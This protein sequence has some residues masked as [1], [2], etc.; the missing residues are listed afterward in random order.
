MQ[1]LAS[2]E[3]VDNLKYNGKKITKRKDGRWWARYYQ[4][5]I[6][7]SVYG[8][9]QNECIANLKKALIQKKKNKSKTILTLEDWI[10]KWIE[11]YKIGK[12][13]ESTL[14]AM[15]SRLKGYVLSNPIASKKLSSI[16]TIELQELLNAIEKD[17]QR[18][19]IFTHLRDIFAKAQQTALIKDNPMQ[20]VFIKKH[21]PKETRAYDNLQEKIFINHCK[22][23]GLYGDFYLLMLYTGLRNGELRALARDDIDFTANT[24]SVSKTYDDLGNITTPKTVESIRTVPLFEP[25]KQILLKYKAVSGIIFNK[26]KCMF[27]KNFKKLMIEIGWQNEGF[28]INSGRHTFI[29]R[30]HEQGLEAKQIEKWVGHSDNSNISKKHYIHI[31]EDFEAKNIDKVNE[32]FDTCF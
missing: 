31:N 14:Y 8:K 4:N 30:L 27:Q 25:A 24:I 19:H 16:T 23:Y 2:S 9:T 5:G 7:K 12:V 3:G 32:I 6:Q 28:T 29:T 10:Y 11:L 18:E 20:F 13:K 15:Q 1:E 17:R 26:S 21:I 22:H